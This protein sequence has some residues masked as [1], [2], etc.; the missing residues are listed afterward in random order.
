MNTQ[1]QNNNGADNKLKAAMKQV[2][3]ALQAK[4]A[5]IDAATDPAV[6]ADLVEEMKA[7]V[8]DAG[9]V[10]DG[11]AAAAEA[12]AKVYKDA[13]DKKEQSGP[14]KPGLFARAK[15]WVNVGIEKVKANKGKTAVAVAAAAAVAATVVYAKR[16]PQVVAATV[17]AANDS[18]DAANAATDGIINTVGGFF[19]R[20]VGAIV[21]GVVSAKNWIVGLFSRTKTVE[22][23]A[24]VTVD[25]Q[26]AAV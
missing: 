25:I 7:M 4:Q 14:T 23:P 26:P 3:E 19:S 11:E 17:D 21:Y 15:A 24:T 5:Q 8:A 22:V 12:Q 20:F 9:L 10:F 18:I 1:A 2:R 6:K 16:N 13:A